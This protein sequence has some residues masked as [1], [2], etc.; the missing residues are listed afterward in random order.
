MDRLMP[1]VRFAITCCLMATVAG[2]IIYTVPPAHAAQRAGIAA[3]VIG[4]VQVSEGERTSP[5]QVKAGMD[6]LMRD[7]VQSEAGRMQVL[8][9]D[10]T[11]F[12]V[13]P[14][15]DLVIDEF[16]Y[17]PVSGAG[18][19]SAN[20][21]KGVLRYVSG[22]VAQVNPG[23]VTIRTPTATIG[24]R[25]TSL[26]V[27]DDPE[28]A[29]TQ[30]IGLLGPGAAN[31]GNLKAGGMTVSAGNSSVEVLRA[32]NGVFVTPGQ[33]LGA[34]VQTPARLLQAMAAGLTGQI[35]LQLAPSGSGNG[36]AASDEEDASANEQADGEAEA[37]AE[38]D[39]GSDTGAAKSSGASTASAGAS[40]G[41]VAAVAGSLGSTANVTGKVS[42]L[43]NTANAVNDRLN[44]MTSNTTGSLPGGVL[45]PALISASWSNT[46]SLTQLGLTDE[47]DLW[48][49]G[50]NGGGTSG[51]FFVTWRNQGSYNSAPFA[52]LDSDNGARIG[53]S[54]GEIIG[55]NQF[56]DGGQYRVILLNFTQATTDIDNSNKFSDPANEFNLKF[57]K[58]ARISRG[59]NGTTI[60]NG[61]VVTSI[62]PPVGQNGHTWT[63]F[64]INHN[65]LAVTIINTVNSVHTDGLG[66][67]LDG[68]GL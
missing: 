53:A 28:T 67:P 35:T 26:F 44:I 7:R 40:A 39:G 49:T 13:G 37:Q 45:I 48:L 62:T 55:I 59:P 22:K 31:D 20:F 66:V 15:S 27:I 54:D 36:E 8:L 6:M 19:V 18:S 24:V 63:G 56:N 41:D 3:G 58:D 61:T 29:D 32:G 43:A 68:G 17:D 11:V 60:T 21:T 10:E 2:V 5:S 50:P 14:N 51:R 12:T 16:V 65:T 38:G 57:I 25:G 33:A 1:G 4:S 52:Q 30:F 42:E 64:D 47:I 34:P 23:N 46:G 9:L